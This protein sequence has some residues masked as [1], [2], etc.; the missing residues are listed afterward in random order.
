LICYAVSPS[1]FIRA[2][3]RL[4]FPYGPSR[5]AHELGFLVACLDVFSEDELFFFPSSDLRLMFFTGETAPS[6]SGIGRLSRERS[7]DVPFFPSPSGHKRLRTD[8]QVFHSREPLNISFQWR[9]PDPSKAFTRRAAVRHSLLTRK[10]V[11][12]TGEISYRITGSPHHPDSLNH[13]PS[14]PLRG[15]PPI[16]WKPPPFFRNH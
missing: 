13:T 9:V 14:P 12:G 8:P 1:H 7:H 6:P 16:V 10:P 2:L 5:S 11:L 15:K 4:F 3:D